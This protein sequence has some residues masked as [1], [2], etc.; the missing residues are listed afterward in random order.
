M[1][2]IVK[3]IGAGLIILLLISG[4]AAFFQLPFSAKNEISLSALSQNINEGRVKE[5]TIKGDK[6]EIIMQDNAKQT[7]KKEVGVPLTETLVNLNVDPAKLSKVNIIVSQQSGLAYFLI[8]SL[9]FILP[10]FV[11]LI[12]FW[13]MFRSAQ[14]GAMQAF[15]FGKSKAR[16]ANSDTEGKKVFFKDVAGLKEAKEEIEEVVE[17]LKDPKKFQKVGAR[18]PRGILLVGPPGTG[19][20]MLAKAV[21]NEAGVPF[22][23]VSGS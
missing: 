2:S 23:Y 19:K 22:F 5:I 6:L 17:F 13:L 10:F 12:L 14:H 16:L 8:N 4:L 3:Y 7:A 20:T 15:S 9:P 1:K 11:I 21:A 18:I